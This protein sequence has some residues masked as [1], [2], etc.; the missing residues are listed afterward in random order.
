MYFYHIGFLCPRGRP[1]CDVCLLQADSQTENPSMGDGLG[2]SFQHPRLPDHSFPKLRVFVNLLLTQEAAPA[3]QAT[4]AAPS[5]SNAG[6][7]CF[8]PH[9]GSGGLWYRAH[10]LAPAQECKR[11]T[12]RA[13]Y[14]LLFLR[15]G[16]V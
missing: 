6:R 16:L 10:P 2:N 5:S 7:C 11:A 1:S 12:I 4:S 13:P 3:T 14:R 15:S 9:E 8:P